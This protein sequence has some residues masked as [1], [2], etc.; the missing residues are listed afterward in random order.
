MK[1]VL[2]LYFFMIAIVQFGI[3]L[4]IYHYYQ[5]QETI[6][7]SR[8]W[9]KSLF[10]N[11]IALVLFGA[12]ILIIKDISQPPFSFT[13]ANTLFYASSVMQTLFCISLRKKIPKHIEIIFFSTI[14]IFVLFFEYLRQ[15]SDFETRTIIMVLFVCFF[16]VFQ[17]V[18][19]KKLRKENN[20]KQLVYLQYVTAIELIFALSR[21]ATIITNNFGI[22]QFEQLPQML[23]IATL[24]QLVMN[25]LSY[26]SVAG[27]WAE[28]ISFL[29][30]KNIAENE[31]NEKKVIEISGL[32][33]E[34][35]QLVFSLL[36]ANKTAT[37]GALSASIAHE[38]NQP[39]TSSTLNIHLLRKAL[40]SEP[41]QIDVCKKIIGTLENDAQR[42]ATIIKSLRSIFT[43]DDA[44]IEFIEVI[45]ILPAVLEVIKKEVDEENIHI[46]LKIDKNLKVQ[47]NPTEF[48]Q[49]LLNLFSNS[50]HALSNSNNDPKKITLEASKI[51]SKIRITITDNGNGITKEFQPN[52]FE[53]L[54]TTK[55]TGMGLGLWLCKHII[56][57]QNGNIWYE[58]NEMGAKFVIELPEAS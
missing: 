17:I 25:T 8:Y 33:K 57:R 12:G 35:E 43:D 21:I 44:N 50:I 55:Q 15:T 20:S 39:L 48:Q 42:A 37:T 30:A 14:F 7:P 4:G 29:N 24:A 1:L 52:L 6:A 40:N 19:I 51:A 16:Y 3:L 2:S 46:D 9:F 53:L 13:I 54:S 58:E 45:K 26:I 32:L 47:F 56:N 34:K 28:K 27:Y 22:K 11:A 31:V 41:I 23:I 18:E 38:L 10:L 5:S 36:K 49:V